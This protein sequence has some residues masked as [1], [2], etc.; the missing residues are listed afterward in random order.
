MHANSSSLKL[1]QALP[2]AQ[3]VQGCTHFRLRQISRV[4]GQHY[5][6]ELAAVGLKT[7][8]YSLLSHVLRLGPLRLG[9]LARAMR[10]DASTLTR[11][12][13]PVLDAGWLQLEPGA[14]KRSRQVQI[15]ASGRAKRNQAQRH[16]K[17]A[18]TRLNQSLGL[19]RIQAL[20]RLLDE[21]LQLFPPPGEVHAV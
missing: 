13:K 11:N 18:Q 5:D 16:W 2:G 1:P 7:T 15:T 10:M 12:L 9:E 20:H 3:A 21:C 4:V 14:D 17:A 19:E 8:Q 6:A